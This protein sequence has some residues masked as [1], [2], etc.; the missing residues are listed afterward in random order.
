MTTELI[1]AVLQVLVFTLIPF[2][3]YLI[4]K[5]KT[6][7][8][9]EYIGLSSSTR[10]ANLL[11][12]LVSLVFLIPAI[13]MALFSAEFME[14]MTDPKTMTGKFRAMG[15]TASTFLLILVTALI[16]TALAEE[17]LFRGFLAKRLISLAG[18]Q[19]GNIL[20]AL[21]FGGL[22]LLIFLAIGSG[23]FYLISILLFSGIGA[24]L[25]VYLNEK[26]A[27]GSIIPGWISHG[28]ANVLAY[29]L[30]AFVF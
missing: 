8:F 25:N 13:G 15:P 28:T 4:Q 23:W 18:Y 5:K 17:I 30:F 22:H 16:K 11:A 10:K 12:I 20:Q 26:V 27:N 6:K 29:T 7:G 21:I 9:F 14:V 2:L 19:W 1:S 3:V 24:Y